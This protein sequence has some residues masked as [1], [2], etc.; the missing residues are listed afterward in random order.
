MGGELASILLVEDDQIDAEAFMR[1]VR[2][3]EL[4]N[5]IFRAKDGVE[6]L[7]I[8]RGESN[9]EKIQG[10]FI[11]LLDLNMPRMGGVEFLEE[12]RRDESLKS[13]VVF[14]LTT[15]AAD[16]DIKGAYESNIAGYITKERVGAG[17]VGLIEMLK[18]YLKLVILP[19]VKQQEGVVFSGE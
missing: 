8:L 1:A 6:A 18:S 14:V 11:V 3:A 7:E 15:S 12:I 16:T 9:L 10:P 13:A 4:P 5:P 17:F 2:K 19:K